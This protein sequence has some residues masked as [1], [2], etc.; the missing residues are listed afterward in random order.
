[1]RTIHEPIDSVRKLAGEQR[2]SDGIQYR[3]SSFCIE[4]ECPEGRLLYHSLT[5]AFLLLEGSEGTDDSA[6][7]ETLVR[8]WFLVPSDFDEIKHCDQIKTAARLLQRNK[9]SINHY[10]I[11]TTTDCNARCFYCFEHGQKRVSMTEQTAHDVATYMLGHANGN[12]ITIRWFGGE[13]LFNAQVIDVISQ[14][15]RDHGADYEATMVSNAYLFDAKTIEKAKDLW[16]LHHVLIT[17]DGTEEVYNRIKAYIYRDGSAYQRVL[18]NIDGLL[19]AGISVTV[20]VSLDAQNAQIQLD[21]VDELGKR[22]GG[23]KNFAARAGLL[24]EYV[25]KIHA[26]ESCRAAMDTLNVLNTKLAGYG[27]REKPLLKT[28]LQLNSCMADNDRNVTIL[29]DGR[30]GRCEH[31]GDSEEVGSIYGGTWDA[32]KVKSWKALRPTEEGCKTCAAYPYCVRLK[33]CNASPEPCNPLFREQRERD[34]YDK[35]QNSYE[36]WKRDSAS[37]T[38]GN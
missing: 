37:E 16:N 4:A 5:G 7:R 34:L 19:D 20:N 36:K 15:L 38:G 31:F 27:I 33:K 2:F 18:S 24:I 26:F 23:R 22:Y 29:P 32:E 13:P 30:I 21:L 10:T 35:M 6:L 3:R 8:R 28:K 9:N 17:I 11:F 12:R 25:G 1:M 14:E